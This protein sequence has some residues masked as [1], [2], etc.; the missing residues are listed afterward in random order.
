ML[1]VYFFQ[2]EEADV[3]DDEDKPADKATPTR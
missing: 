2:A 1:N 3:E